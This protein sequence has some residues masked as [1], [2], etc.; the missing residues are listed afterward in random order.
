MTVDCQLSDEEMQEAFRLNTTPS[1][2]FRAA[3]SNFYAMF[4]VLAAL[5]AA[6]VNLVDPFTPNW[7]GIVIVFLF[8]ALLVGISLQRLRGSIRKAASGI[9]AQ[10]AQMTLDAQGVSMSSNTGATS[11][12]PWS[13]FGGWKEGNLVFTIGDTKEFKTVAKSNLSDSQ[14]GEIGRASC[15]ER[16]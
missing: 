11:F 12:T 2:W 8:G 10:G 7:N 3:L 15:R 6:V 1:F 5:I 4:C 14:I 9:N 16:V 13:Q